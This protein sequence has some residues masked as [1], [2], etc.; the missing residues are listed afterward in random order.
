MKYGCNGCGYL[1]AQW[2]G[3][4][5]RCRDESGLVALD[6]GGSAVDAVSVLDVEPERARHQPTGVAE[7]DRVLGG[8]LVPGAAVLVAGEPGVGKSTLLLQVAASA[9]AAGRAVLFASGEESPPQIGARALRVGAAEAMLHVMP[10]SSVATVIAAAADLKPSLI[11]IDSI[12]TIHASTADAVAGTTASVRMAA[13]EL[14]AW[15]KA[16][17]IPLVLVGHVNKEGAIAGPKVLEHAV[18]VVAHLEGDHHRDLR[19]LRCRKNRYGP[20]SR[21]GLFRLMEAGMVEVADASKALV[22]SWQGDVAGSVAFP[23]FEGGRAVVVEIQAL[24]TP[25]SAA[26][27]RRSVR[28]IDSARLHQVVAVLERHAGMDFRGHD[29]YV[30][31]SG[32]L[33]VKDPG[34]DLPVALALASSLAGVPLGRIGAWGEVGLTG[35]VRSVAHDDR[36]RE[37]AERIGLSGFITPAPGSARIRA[38][39]GAAGVT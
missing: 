16:N 4:C 13:A 26:N 10:G 7:F 9:A 32:G 22:G 8:G 15:A 17:G 2:L 18:D 11:V 5:P 27:Q 6:D 30:G 33:R 14:V 28:G 39:V 29:I 21:I 3:F 12:Q 1:S 34:A 19:V 38:V 37:E 20:T 25:T 35:E 24:V 31:V 36:R 23:A